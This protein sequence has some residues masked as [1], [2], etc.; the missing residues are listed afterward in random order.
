[1]AGILVEG[2]VLVTGVNRAVSRRSRLTVLRR[3]GSSMAA[4]E[5]VSGIESIR[6]L[7]MAVW[8]A[9]HDDDCDPAALAELAGMTRS[10][11]GF[12]GSLDGR[13]DELLRPTGFTSRRASGYLG[14]LDRRVNCLGRVAVDPA[15]LDA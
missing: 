8:F 9:L 5:F 4:K 6:P 12:H 10:R 11:K 1:M 13:L 14:F 15:G 3:E 7:G 2:G